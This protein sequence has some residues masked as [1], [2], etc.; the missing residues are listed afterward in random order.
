MKILRL[1]A[2]LAATALA[3]MASHATT[4]FS[5]DF[6]SGTPVEVSNAPVGFTGFGW[7]NIGTMGYAAYGYGE[8]FYRSDGTVT[9]L[10]TGL[11]AHTSVDI[12]A[13][14]ATIDSW[15]GEPPVGCCNP[16]RLKIDVDGTTVFDHSFT[17]FPG[18]IQSYGGPALV[19]A[20][21]NIGFSGW[22]DQGYDLTG[23]PSLTGIAHTG[24]TLKITFTAYGA[25]WQMG[26][27]ES[28][29][30]DNV[31]IMTNAVPEPATYGLMLLG[32]GIVGGL[33]RRRR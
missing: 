32:L 23:L 13:F 27:D 24:S 28:F 25:G 10:L 31:K 1:A 30:I 26:D 15:D 16:D 18:N 20:A 2:V 19:P 21:T 17:V 6:E 3:S 14:I 8:H 9:I 4:V 12:G 29:A 22:A 5:T 7:G 11:G 33:A